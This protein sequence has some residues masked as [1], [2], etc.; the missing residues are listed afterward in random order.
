MSVSAGQSDELCQALRQAGYA[1]ATV[2]GEVEQTPE[3]QG[4]QVT[5]A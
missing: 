4:A 2:I 1:Q 3:G 5:L